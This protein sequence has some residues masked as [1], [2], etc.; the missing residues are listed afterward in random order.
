MC[1]ISKYQHNMSDDLTKSIDQY[2]RNKQDELF[3]AQVSCDPDG[4]ECCWMNIFQYG[5]HTDIQ[6][7]F[8]KSYNIFSYILEN[9]AQQIIEHN[10]DSSSIIYK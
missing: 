8:H 6:M 7:Q 1:Q 9:S 3:L 10:E 4:T 5:Q 2:Q